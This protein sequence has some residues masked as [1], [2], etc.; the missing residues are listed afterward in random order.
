MNK[1]RGKPPQKA[2][3]R[4][5]PKKPSRSSADHQRGPRKPAGAP[6]AKEAPKQASN[7]PAK[8]DS[9]VFRCAPGLSKTLQAEL[10]H[11][12]LLRQDDR[13]DVLWQRNH[14]LVFAPKLLGPPKRGDVRIAEEVHR[15]LIYGRYKIT[16]SQLDRLAQQ[17]TARDRRW[18]IVA[19][20]DGNHFDR[21]D[22]LRWLIK[23]LGRRGVQV[24][25]NAAR[26]CFLFCID[27]A[28][29]ACALESRAEDVAERERREAER[30]G[31]LPPPVAAAMAFL[32]RA[33]DDD[34][35]LD[36]VCG[37][38]TLLAEARALAPNARLH[39]LDSDA[40]AVK[41]ARRNLSQSERIRIEQGD[42]RESELPDASVSLVLANLPF[43][44][45]HGDVAENR[46]LYGEIL[47]ELRRV[48][49]P[50]GFRAVL[51]AAD[52]DLLSEAARAQGFKIGRKV[53]VR[54]R[55]EAA[56]IL[57]VE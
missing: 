6:R 36:P 53:P 39:G 4:A 44:K 26:T 18:R 16:P 33:R 31:S 52:A 41:A 56:T 2:R 55:G 22:I 10:R 7:A 11:R 5:A 35:I 46:T 23:E 48:A 15:C 20:A 57:V 13:L 28:Y 50:S 3:D 9:W 40:R 38:G 25:E 49:A 30:E 47:R 12:A 51:M 29:Y 43:G 32:G 14:D 37:S 45:Q 34:T 21:R 19:T 54:L 8:G 1:A 42:A 24:S 27:Q 17:L